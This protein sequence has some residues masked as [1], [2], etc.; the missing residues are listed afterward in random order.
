[1]STLTTRLA[2]LA[3]GVILAAAA[4][5]R[6]G[7]AP[8][9]ESGDSVVVIPPT[10]LEVALRF[11]DL[12]S[13]NDPAC[14]ELLAPPL[15]DSVAELNEPPWQVFGRWRGFDASG[16]LTEVIQD[17]TGSRTSYFCTIARMEGPAIVRMDFLLSRQGWLI[18]GFGEEIPEAV[19]DSLNSE[20]TARMILASPQIRF[21]IRIARELLD[22]CRVDSVLCFSSLS[23][24]ME[25]GTSFPEYVSGLS[26]DGYEQLALSNIRRSAKLQIIQDRATFN[27]TNA[28]VELNGF[29]AAW[30]EMAYL[31][32]AVLRSR[33]EAMQNLRLNG[34]WVDPDS[35]LDLRRLA[36]LDASFL[37]VSDLVEQLDTLSSTWPALLTTGTEE[38]LQQMLIQLDPHMMEQRAEDEA[39]VTVWRALGVEMNGDQDPERVVYWAGNLYLFQGTHTGYRLAWRTYEGY[40]SDYHA[41]FASQPS[42]APGCRD[43]TFIGNGGQYEYRL[44]YRS[45]TPVMERTQ[46]ASGSDAE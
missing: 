11:S 28:P 38:P 4:G 3:A 10:P 27:I 35:G 31:G 18:E 15:R 5:C 1:M 39:G 2:A 36:V 19:M 43:V 12:L 29:V 26:Q 21:E 37:E 45:G 46:L 8:V 33:H 6:D 32:K 13:M 9:P 44:T 41:D 20:R 40:D 42:L 14:F 30:R 34:A 7:G 24:A 25:H 17:S 23:A 16:R 22:D